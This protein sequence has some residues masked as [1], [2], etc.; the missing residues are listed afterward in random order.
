M[1]NIILIIIL[2]IIMI[3]NI[4]NIYNPIKIKDTFLDPVNPQNVIAND[5][6]MDFKYISDPNYTK[7]ILNKYY[8]NDDTKKNGVNVNQHIYK[9][10]VS[11]CRSSQDLNPYVY[12]ADIS[13]HCR[14]NVR[15]NYNTAWWHKYDTI[16]QD[17]YNLY[18]V[19]R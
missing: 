2:I 18:G 6:K 3:Y 17:I 7:N 16:A 11:N 1:N 12:S 10:P 19:R 9:N 8:I 4:Y 14:R 13:L 15:N 5:G